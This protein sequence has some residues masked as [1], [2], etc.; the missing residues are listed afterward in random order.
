MLHRLFALCA[1]VFALTACAGHWDEQAPHARGPSSGSASS[2]SA[3]PAAVEGDYR[4]VA[5][6]KIKVTVAGEG[7][8]SGEFPV[9]KAG[10]L[11]GPVVGEVQAA[12]LTLRQFESLY[13]TKLRE[14][15]IL[16]NPRVSAEVTNLRPIYVLGEVK[17]PGQ[18][19]FVNGMTVQKAVALAEGYTYLASENTVEIT[20]G[21]TKV[22]LDFTA[23]TK[24]LPG[25]EVRVPSRI[26]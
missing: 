17:R 8:L 10:A 18:Y 16:R 20:R 26:F 15:E 7:D 3:L 9:D 6:D 11:K 2:A 14:G 24:V 13:A 5:N 1:F 22:T 19:A 23:E 4:I 12:G 21:G 25:D